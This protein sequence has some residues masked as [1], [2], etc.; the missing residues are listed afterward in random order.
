MVIA[1]LNV[2]VWVLESLSDYVAAVL[3]RGLSQA[4]EHELRVETYANVQDLDVPWYEGWA[5]GRGAV[6]HQR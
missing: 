3:W 1:A 5:P 6:D 2:A 4:V